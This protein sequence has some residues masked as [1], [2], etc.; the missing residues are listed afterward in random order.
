MTDPTR[1]HRRQAS[2]PH[3]RLQNLYIVLFLVLGAALCVAEVSRQ[4]ALRGQIDLV[5]FADSLRD[6]GRRSG[7]ILTEA[8]QLA[9]LSDEAVPAVLIGRLQ[10]RIGVLRSRHAAIME[11]VAGS[12]QLAPGV[13][14]PLERLEPAIEEID[15]VA[16]TAHPLQIAGLIAPAVEEYRSGLQVA[17]GN[18]L[19]QARVSTRM[20]SALSLSLFGL[21]AALL[22]VEALFLILPATRS[23]QRQWNKL[24]ESHRQTS[25]LSDRF[26]AL[27]ESTAGISGLRESG[28]SGST[29]IVVPSP[30]EDDPSIID[31][32][33]LRRV[34]AGL[35]LFEAALLNS[36][37]GVFIV[38]RGDP[39]RVVFCNDAAV[40]LTGLPRAALIGSSP[41][42]IHDGDEET[43]QSM[44]RLITGVE[45]G[46]LECELRPGEGKVLHLEIGIVPVGV[47]RDGPS[48][49]VLVYRDV[50]EQVMAQRAL[51]SAA[52]RFELIG[53]VSLDGIY[54]LDL[55][56]G[57]CWRNEPLV[58]NFGRPDEGEAFF[59]W[60]RTR[61]HE[62]DA[63]R[64]IG[65]FGEFVESDRSS[66]QAEYRQLRTDGTW[67]RV[68]DHASMLRDS[69]GR[70]FRLVGSL[71]D[72]T[73][74][75]EQQ[76]LIEQNNA[77]LQQ[78]LDDQT[79][80]V[81]R[82]RE[83]G[84]LLFVNNA[85][86]QYFGRSVDDL[87]GTSFLDLIPADG[88]DFARAAMRSLNAEN[89]MITADH[90]V[91][92]ADGTIRWTRWTDRVIFD[93][94]GEIVAYQ[95]I[96]RDVTEEIIAK[97]KLEEAEGRYRAFIRNS[98]EA[99]FRIEVDPPIDIGLPAEEQA[100]LIMERGVI[101][102]VNEAFSKQYGRESVEDSVGMPLMDLFN[103][104][105]E[106]IAMTLENIAD[107]VRQNYQV[108]D[109]ESHEVKADGTP[110]TFSN[111]TVGIVEN[112]RLT[113]IWGTQLDITE[114]RRAEHDLR[115]TNTL[116]QLFIEHAPAAVAMFDNDMRY[117]AASERWKRDYGL[118]E[119]SLIGRSHY[120]VFPEIGEEWKQIHGRCLA[121]EAMT[122]EEDHFERA[123]G[124]SQWIRWD[125]RPWHDEQGRVGGIVMFTEEI[126]DRKLAADR[127][128][129]VNA[130]QER[131]LTELDHR[132]KNALGALLSLIEL[133][134]QNETDV[135]SY[136]AS[137]ARR[138]RS[139]ADV[140]AMLS[141]SR[142]KPLALAEIVKNITPAD[143]AGEI[144][145]SGPE[146]LV[147]AHQ[148]TPLAMVLQEFVSNSLKYGALTCVG[149]VASV[150]WAIESEAEDGS[151]TVRLVWSERGGPP[152]EPPPSEGVGTQLIRG[153]ARFELRGSIDFG[154]DDPSGVCHTLVC[155]LRDD[156]PRA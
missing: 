25:R 7:E 100:R 134:T 112:G 79:E 150:S 44:R 152:V 140:H 115:T 1:N 47:D 54:D 58:R 138:V 106:L 105:P 32:S 108:S 86:A 145:P 77:R 59:E 135:P 93:A 56:T 31:L 28:R 45:P 102:E 2:I 156:R 53:R 49:S 64:V 23:L 141:E 125:I 82:Y 9:R 66:W 148:A 40:E 60:L 83:G 69:S 22:L 75:R 26:T 116:L 131:L 120:D 109:L 65:G 70:P 13:T 37:D 27:I 118:T 98:S 11:N 128:R 151:Q 155:R 67:A 68:R 34:E 132:V 20:L 24:E 154:F 38:E 46:E 110:V 61:I 139:M 6:Q 10:D 127:L 71:Q 129:E 76:W 137:I 147:P 153:F 72:V 119:Q 144:S 48:H 29:R 84:V 117:I 143:T 97:R 41:D 14:A 103:N 104:D 5:D 101:A 62:D 35:R 99:I 15:A 121:G 107:L 80:L 43:L 17:A 130:Q 52:D 126:T 50:T 96:G 19:E 4:R 92:R 91:Q 113:R 8:M 124:S 51:R 123:D 63:E 122:R 114:Q 55:A 95:A 12:E 74:A 21:I 33:E 142:W 42:R 133:G 81:C 90:E 136:A 57:E 87:I 149:G 146:V 3:R 94:E 85:Y 78:I 16:A 73:E 36:T 88:R 89:P 30:A 39:G 18:A 111:N